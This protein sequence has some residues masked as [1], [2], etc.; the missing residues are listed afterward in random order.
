MNLLTGWHWYRGLSDNPIYLR[1]KGT[2]GK[3]NPFFDTLMRFI[4][5]IVL[6]GIGLG[7]CA[8][9][10]NPALF[11]SNGNLF[12][13]WCLLFLPGVLLSMLTI[14]GSFMAPALTAPIISLERDRGTWEIL[15]ATPQS[16]RSILMAKLLGALSRLRIWPVL[17]V[18][19]LFQGLILFF[20]LTFALGE[21][22]LWNWLLGAAVI[23]RPWSEILFAAFAGLFFSTAVGSATMALVST[24]ALV[25]IFKLFN[26][27]PL[28]LGLFTLSDINSDIAMFAMGSVGPTAVYIL[29]IIVLWLG[30]FYQASRIE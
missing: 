27:S 18:L 7:F 25:V 6:G 2:W 11:G 8:G 22:T 5:F 4:P 16:M 17:F 23:L 28:W 19:S 13:V 14:L 20:A 9:F 12:I 30:I 26:S 10:S 21:F 24:Y 1:E 3:P 15:R 29:A